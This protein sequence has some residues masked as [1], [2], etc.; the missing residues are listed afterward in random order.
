[1]HFH[2]YRL[3]RNSQLKLALSERW[4]TDVA[5]ILTCL[6]LQVSAK[7]ELTTIIE[8]LQARIGDETLFVL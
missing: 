6:G 3:D 1:M 2:A 8:M 5:G 7:V 4:S